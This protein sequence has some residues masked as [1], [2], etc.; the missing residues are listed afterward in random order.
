MRE[1]RLEFRSIRTIIGSIMYVRAD[2]P[3]LTYPIGCVCNLNFLVAQPVDWLLAA[4]DCRAF[5]AKSF[6]PH[7]QVTLYPT[8]TRLTNTCSNSPKQ[9][10]PPPSP[11]LHPSIRYPIK[12]K[13]GDSL[14]GVRCSIPFL[15]NGIQ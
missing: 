6:G 7:T 2:C 8:L 9:S 4:V 13:L 12:T 11:T 5:S 14:I 3:R 1:I 15:P 10:K